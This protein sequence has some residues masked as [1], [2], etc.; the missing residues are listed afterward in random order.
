MAGRPPLPL[1]TVGNI[2]IRKLD[3]GGFR[4]SAR[5]RS[6]DGQLHRVTATGRTAASARSELKE[7]MTPLLRAPQALGELGSTSRFGDLADAWLDE[8]MADANTSE[9][10]RADYERMLRTLVLPTFRTLVVREV[11]VRRIER[12]LA[13]RQTASSGQARAAHTILTMVMGFAVRR[14]VAAASPVPE[15]LPLP[16]WSPPRA[17]EIDA[18]RAAARDWRTAQGV[19]GPR[20]D[21][22]VR[23]LIDVLLGTSMTIGE[24]LALRVC[25][26]D[27]N[28]ES[29][30]IRV[31]G[32][33]LV[34][35]GVGVVR[36]PYT[37]VDP[38]AKREQLSG[39]AAQA[40]ARRTEGGGDDVE[41]LL[42]VTRNGTPLVPHNVRRAIREILQ[43]AGADRLDLGRVPEPRI[44]DET[45]AIWQSQ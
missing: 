23:D 1:G 44:Q 40:V 9:A 7:R 42:F 43:L 27:A 13:L 24:V 3:N 12:F 25:D 17:A 19:R 35:T 21:G 10:T 11:T 8:L 34:R 37:G 29:L 20:P 36:K 22:Q 16:A 28:V 31:A 39:F 4:A 32:R 38:R 18:I 41:R 5:F 6:R 33:I 2:A 45:P 14:G 15:A 30:T 26:V